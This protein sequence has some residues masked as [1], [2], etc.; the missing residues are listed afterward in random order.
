M[1]DGAD[2]ELLV[3]AGATADVEQYEQ[4]DDVAAQFAALVERL[5]ADEQQAAVG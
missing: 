4:T 3:P 5:E 1:V 2:D